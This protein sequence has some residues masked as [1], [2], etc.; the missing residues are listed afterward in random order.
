MQFRLPALLA[1]CLCFLGDAAATSCSPFK[2]RFLFAC[3]TQ[4]CTG[5]FSV[6]DVATA[7]GCARLPQVEAIDPRAAP[8]ALQLVEAN[9][10]RGSTG[11]LAL[12]MTRS[13]WD[14]PSRGPTDWFEDNV[15]S[16]VTLIS[17]NASPAAIAAVRAKFVAAERAQYLAAMRSSILSWGSSAIAV[18]ALI[19]SVHV[20][21]RTLYNPVSPRRWSPFL[22]PLA[23]Q[24]TLGGVA[25][26]VLLKS[27][28]GQFWPG[29]VLVPAVPVILVCEGWA[30]FLKLRD[31][32]RNAVACDESGTKENPGGV[33]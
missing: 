23:V 14:N 25:A 8:L 32:K 17:T 5:L 19:Y 18:L 28:I 33:F 15:S 20:Y 12:T 16:A 3:E 9:R 21:F 6:R 11:I 4:R 13:F 31:E 26:V 29:L 30:L 24:F 7:G 27:I 22:L 2:N 1:L 10:P